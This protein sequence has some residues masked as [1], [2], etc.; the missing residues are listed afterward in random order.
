[1]RYPLVVLLPGYNGTPRCVMRAFLDSDAVA[2]HPRVDGFV[3]APH[4]HGNTF[5]RGP[6]EREVM[7]VLDWMLKTYPIDAARV[8][9]SGVSMGGT[10]AAHLA[11]RYPERFAASAPLCGYQ[12]FFVRKDTADRPIRP[13]ENDL[14]RHLSP[15]SWAEN[16]KQLPLHV[17]HG[18]KDFPLENSKVLIE[19]YQKLGQ[20][21]VQEWPEIGHSVW[22]LAYDGARLWPWLSRQRRDPEP[23]EVVVKTDS[24]RY[25]RRHWAAITQL[26]RPGRMGWLDA[27]ITAPDRI[28]VSTRAVLALEL[29]RAPKHLAGAALSVTIDRSPLTFAPDEP[30]RAIRSGP[31]WIKGVPAAAPLRKRAHLEGG[32]RDAYLERLAFVWGSRDE[33]TARANREL[34]EWLARLRYGADLAYPVLADSDVDQRLESE[35][36]LVLVGT[37]R[38]HRLLAELEPR[39]PVRAAADRLELGPH[40]FRGDEVGAIYVFPNPRH[41]ERY[42]TVVTATTARG[43]WR[44]LSLPQLLPDFVVFDAGLAPAAGQQVLGSARVLAAGFF[45]NDWSI[46]KA[47]VDETG[48]RAE[49]QSP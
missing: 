30:M 29:E 32:L 5:Y 28:A 19:R 36:S 48:T 26:E 2:A 49:A 37:P 45:E 46:P 7:A 38:D 42:L 44:A 18:T 20:P 17:A 6:G 33:A 47:M 4:A 1:V 14:M 34:A 16:G 12:S 10:G 8:S 9:I 21:V 41:P 24:L 39:L 25:G 3:V 23:R 27:R 15:A 43:I 35:R 40:V 31:G 22:E 11:L 13:W